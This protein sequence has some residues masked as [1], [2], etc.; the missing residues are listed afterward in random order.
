MTL[1]DTLRPILTAYRAEVQP[2]WS[3]ATAHEDFDGKVGD[4]AGQCGVTS[5][6]LQRRLR[7][8]HG[9]ETGFV[10]GA[11][12]TTARDYDHCWLQVKAPGVWLPII[13]LTAD[14]F[15]PTQQL[16]V[17]CDGWQTLFNRGIHYVTYE[18]L[19]PE[20]LLADPVGARLAILTSAVGR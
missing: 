20:E 1:T 12:R 17:V 3:P 13:D 11:L 6:W 2:H 9:I 19:F 8:D 5:A 14:Q 15:P 10:V 18:W 7:E 16:P 4:P